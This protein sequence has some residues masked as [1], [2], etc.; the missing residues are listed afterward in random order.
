MKRK[1]L[2]LAVLSVFALM[3]TTILASC[4]LFGSNETVVPP[5]VES[6]EMLKDKGGY[7][8]SN[9]YLYNKDKGY[10]MALYAGDSFLLSI[11]YNNPKKYAISYVT[12]NNEKIMPSQFESGS[13]KTNT[14]IKITVPKEA[15]RGEEMTFTVKNILYNT[16]SETKKIKF[17]EDIDM[18]FK[19]KVSPTYSLTLNYQN[20]DYRANSTKKKHDVSSPAVVDFGAEMGTLGIMDKNYA[21]PNGL[22]SKAGGWLFE[23]WYT[24]PNG[25]GQLISSKDTYYF[26][27]NITLYAYYTRIFE[28]EIVPLSVPT[29]DKVT[30]TNGDKTSELDVRY[31]SGAI[32]T[33]DNTRGKFPN[34]SIDDTITDEKIIKDEKT[35]QTTVSYSEYP[36]IKI[37]NKAFKDVNNI[38]ELYIGKY[39]TEI[40]A[41]AFDNCNALE[42]ASFSKNSRLKY[43]GDYA[44]Q[45]T[46]AMGITSAFT[47]PETVE[48]IGNFAFRYSG[49]KTTTN[50][51][52]NESVLHIKPQYKFIGVGCFFETGFSQVVF[53]AGC[54]FD[55]QIGMA[56]A[57]EIEKAAGWAEPKPELNRIGAN[58]FGNC[59]NLREVKFE[60]D[61]GEAN[62]LNIIPD[63]CFDAGNYT[64]TL[65][66]NLTLAEGIEF[67]GD[68]AFNYQS[69]ISRLEIPASVTEIGISAFYNCSNVTSLTFKE[70]SRLVTLHSRCFGNMK[71]IDRV[72]I[73]STDFAKYGNG[74]FEGCSR[75]KSIEFPNLNDPNL[76]PKGFARSENGKEVL[77]QHKFSDLLY[78]TFESGS[79][80][81]GDENSSSYS[82]P[83][84][85]FCK[86][87]I[88]E[89]F[90]DTILESKATYT[91]K[92]GEAYVTIAGPSQFRNVVFVHNIDL[93]KTYTNPGASVGEEADV[94]IA[95]QEI[96]GGRDSTS[97]KLVGYSIVYWSVRSKN[98][99]L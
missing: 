16:G 52:I 9:E 22:P 32:I 56:E 49:W 68:E 29:E 97:K 76:I 34:M 5:T 59:A 38:K 15:S 77:A 23:G 66:E 65:I 47:I 2:L 84:R 80:E 67:I 4:S 27:S 43:I 37:K 82:L 60:N 73:I 8:E 88:M 79:E 36:V 6:V 57:K 21:E 70:G 39:V 10:S 41:Y 62:A 87:T 51:G 31:S 53:D 95:L 96:Y 13:T 28:Y 45:T 19:V 61:A 25:E 35:G 48:Y 50:N 94:D 12:V 71:A 91:F 20:A 86:G 3:A 54:R 14:I 81:S 72:E 64:V 74:P 7:T 92:D 46:K 26:W 98:I 42:K 30:V 33:K 93:I 69:K 55:S 58:L 90:K 44:F 17:S 78:G 83:T 11:K 85:I 40:G 1:A 99:V 24:E 18:N 75:L 63:N 89:K